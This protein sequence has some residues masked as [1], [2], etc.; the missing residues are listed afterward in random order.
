MQLGLRTKI[1]NF[2]S[3][4]RRQMSANHIGAAALIC[5]TL[6]CV[7]CVLNPLWSPEFELRAGIFAWG[8]LVV[9]GNVICWMLIAVSLVAEQGKLLGV[10]SLLL[11]AATE[12]YTLPLLAMMIGVNFFPQ[13]PIVPAPLIVLSIFLRYRRKGGSRFVHVLVGG[14][15]LLL[16]GTL[17]MYALPRIYGPTLRTPI[18]LLS[19]LLAVTT[20]AYAVLRALS[21]KNRA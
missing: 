3:E 20:L 18:W 1:H 11:L 19:V 8:S 15:V 9:I 5:S 14:W 10:I 17:F 12:N 21:W 6:T 7:I 4:I 13:L 2:P 16:M